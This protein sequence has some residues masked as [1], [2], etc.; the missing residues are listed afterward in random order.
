L[1]SFFFKKERTSNSVGWRSPTLVLGL[2]LMRAWLGSRKTKKAS[3][4][5]TG[6]HAYVQKRR[7]YDVFC[8]LINCCIEMSLELLSSF[9]ILKI[10]KTQ[11]LL[12]I[13][14]YMFRGATFLEY[15]E[16]K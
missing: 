5:K 3:N 10:S 15:R 11:I 16:S 13:S 6:L 12:N 1:Q 8:A 4:Y 2:C 14:K 9:Y 7:T